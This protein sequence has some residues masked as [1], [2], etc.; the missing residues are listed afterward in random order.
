MPDTWISRLRHALGPGGYVD[1]M[2]RSVQ[3]VVLYEAFRGVEPCMNTL[4]PFQRKAAYLEQCTH[5]LKQL[6]DEGVLLPH[7]SAEIMYRTMSS[8]APLDGTAAITRHRGLQQELEQLAQQIKPFWVTG[9]SHEEAV[10]RLAHYLFESRSDGSHR[11]R[12]T[13]P[14]WEHANNHVMLTFRLYY[15]GDQLDT[16]FPAP[17]LMVNLQELRKK[18]RSEV[19]DSAVIKPSPSKKVV[20]EEEEEKRLTVQEVREHLELL[21][22][23]EGV[24][25]DEE[26]AQRKRDLFLSLP[27]VPAKR[28]KAD[29]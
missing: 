29:V 18:E 23:F 11:G 1:Q 14:M 10:D 8:Q 9:R 5:L 28:S 22:E 19:P 15:Q 13:P 4:R 7:Q 2:R 27:T 6:V 25:P 3:S 24:I 12:P 20:V 16:N 21:K 17:V 26:I